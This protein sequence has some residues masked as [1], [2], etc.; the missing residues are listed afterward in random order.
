M[1]TVSRLL[2]DEAPLVVQ[3]KLACAV[4]LNEAIFLQLVH[5]WL[6][7]SDKVRDGRKWTYNPQTAWCEQLPFLSAGTVRRIIKTLKDSK[8]LLVGRYNRSQM[9]KTTWYSIDY[10]KLD[11]AVENYEETPLKSSVE[12]EETDCSNDTPDVLNLRTSIEQMNES[13]RANCAHPSAQIEHMHVRKLSTPIPKNN[14]KTYLIRQTDSQADDV[15]NV[16]IDES[17]DSAENDVDDVDLEKREFYIDCIRHHVERLPDGVRESYGERLLA[18][19][20]KILKR[21]KPCVIDRQEIEPADVLR[22][23]DALACN[24]DALLRAYQVIDKKSDEV[25]NRVGYAVSVLYNTAVEAV[26]FPAGG[27]EESW[28]G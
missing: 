4:G 12:D 28:I 23:L 27:G 6:Q 3:P 1:R 25:Q 20:E 14:T 26:M 13:M 19:A 16:Q 22:E 18:L 21:G 11:E 5:Y 8:I 10:E 7:K 24:E 15:L 2:F 17:E 9:D